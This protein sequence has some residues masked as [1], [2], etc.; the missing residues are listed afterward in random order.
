L[1]GSDD[2]TLPNGQVGLI[3]QVAAVLESA[4]ADLHLTTGQDFKQWCLEGKVGTS[5]VE[6]GN[7]K[8]SAAE[9]SGALEVV[10]KATHPPRQAH[11][12]ERH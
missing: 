4:V 8:V 5:H 2:D 9:H 1:G 6:V 10:G 12:R 11:S 7:L 3:R